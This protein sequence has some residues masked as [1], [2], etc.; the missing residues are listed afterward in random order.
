MWAYLALQAVGAAQ[1]GLFTDATPAEMAYVIDHSD[2]TFVLAKDQEQCDKLLE[3]RAQIPKVRRV[4]YWDD[5]AC[6]TTTSRG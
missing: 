3:I 4:I 6:G 2:A 1:V 5:A